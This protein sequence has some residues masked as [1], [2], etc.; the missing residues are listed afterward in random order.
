[1]PKVLI[2]DDSALMRKVLKEVL[3]GEA[4]FEVL[5]ARNG[6]EA[7]EMNL[8]WQPDVVTL[9]IN[10][11]EMDGLTAL[12]Y[13]MAQ[14]RVPVVVISS[15]TEKDALVTFEALELGAI[16]YIT[17]PEGTI[18]INL[19]KIKDEILSKVTVALKARVGRSWDIIGRTAK[20]EGR[21]R[22]ELLE[23]LGPPPAFSRPDSS[24]GGEMWGIV[25]IGASTGGPRT[26]EEILRALPKNFPCPVL[27]AQHMPGAFTRSFAE[28]LDSICE[29]Q[30]KEVTSLM[31]IEKGVVYLAKG[32]TDLTL[33]RRGKNLVLQPKPENKSFVWHPSVEALGRSVLENFDPKR[34]IAVMLTGMGNDGVEAFSEIKMKGGRTI[35]EAEETA[36]VFGMPH[37]L[38][39]RNGATVVL[40]FYRIA[41]QLVKWIDWW[42]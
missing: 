27:V 18:S 29:L 36:I 1:M 33:G 38:I 39:K 26:L 41:H 21:P 13:M 40:P 8:R 34:T 9:D 30:V 32:G 4:G 35:A 24:R 31:P 37:E 5:T 42:N 28:R 11:P 25:V 10:M 12:S 14:R 7:V 17:K 16:D 15:L 6:R 2:V 20:R 23:G 22:G 3:E 19:H